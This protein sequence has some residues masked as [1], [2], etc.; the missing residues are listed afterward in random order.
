MKNGRFISKPMT[1]TVDTGN[2]GVIDTAGDRAVFDVSDLTG[3]S[4]YVNQLVDPGAAAV[5]LLVEKSVDGLNWAV[6][7][8]LADTDFVASANQ[9]EELSLS[10]ANGM[11]LSTKQIRVT[12]TSIA[13]GEYSAVVV[14]TQRDGYR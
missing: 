11:P 4:I 12:A 13:G 9:A 6:V 3:I 14:G 10:D 8:T 2:T 5:S 1:L 7:G